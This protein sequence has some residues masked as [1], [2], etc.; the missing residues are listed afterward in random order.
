MGLLK[1]LPRSALLAVGLWL[2]ATAASGGPLCDSV[3]ELVFR[4]QAAMAARIH[5]LGY[6]ADY[7]YVEEDFRA[8]SRSEVACTRRVWMMGFGRQRH[9]FETV[10]LNGL[11]L[12]GTEMDREIRDLKSKG[13]VTRESRMPF[14]LETRREFTYTLSGVRSWQ[15]RDAWVVSFEPRVRTDRTV[16]GRALVLRETGDVIRMEFKPARLPFVVDSMAIVLDYAP[17]D[18]LWLPMSLRLDLSLRLAV[19]RRTLLDRHI[20]IDDN[21]S[22]YKFNSGLTERF[23]EGE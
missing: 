4:R 5:D 10:T 14:L 13:L 23:F 9:D 11:L 19:F 16:R 1:N 15:G 21:Y 22:D 20:S 2:A 7:R 6:F 3:V 18:D 8:G 17:H 12:A